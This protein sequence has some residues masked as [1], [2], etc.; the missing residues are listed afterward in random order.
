MFFAAWRRYGRQRHQLGHHSQRGTLT[1]DPFNNGRICSSNLS[2]FHDKITVKIQ[3]NYIKCDWNLWA[4]FDQLGFCEIQ[5][6]LAWRW[7]GSTVS[8]LFLLVRIF[9]LITE[10]AAIHGHLKFN[11][12]FTKMSVK[13]WSVVDWYSERTGDITAPWYLWPNGY[14][15][16]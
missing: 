7:S 16:S 11:R 15:F 6:L 9:R 14:G 4:R 10:M 13:I 12:N 8:K 3:Q 5:W 2:S 1:V